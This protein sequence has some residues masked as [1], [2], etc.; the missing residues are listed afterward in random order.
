MKLHEFLKATKYK[1]T[2]GFEYQWECYGLNAFSI[3]REFS[4][5][6]N[7]VYSASCI[8]DTKSQNLFEVSFWDYKKRKTYRWI[9]RSFFKAYK[10]ECKKRNVSFSMASDN[11]KYEDV[12]FNKIISIIKKS[13]R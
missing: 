3:S 10:S 13:T 8:F 4:R 1:I 6:N 12:Y 7:F 11:M 9:K 5:N 2:D